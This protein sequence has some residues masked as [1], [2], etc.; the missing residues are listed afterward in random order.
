[1]TLSRLG[2]LL[3]RIGRGILLEPGGGGRRA[4]GFGGVDL[5]S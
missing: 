4:P 5:M 3:P 2:R 1:M